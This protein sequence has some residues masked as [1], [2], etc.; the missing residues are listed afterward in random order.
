MIGLYS[1]ILGQHVSTE[2]ITGTFGINIVPNISTKVNL[3][4]VVCPIVNNEWTT[5]IFRETSWLKFNALLTVHLYILKD[6]CGSVKQP[7]CIA[8]NC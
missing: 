4:R 5:E 3:S 2:H 8:L 6:D 7:S 1:K